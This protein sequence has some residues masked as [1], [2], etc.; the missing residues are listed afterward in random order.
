MQ[1]SETNSENEKPSLIYIHDPMCSWCWGFRPA[2][3][4]LLNSL[5][6]ANKDI[7]GDINIVRLVGGLAPDSD[8]PMPEEMKQHLSAIWRTIQQH[9]PGTEFNFDFWTE[10]APRRSTYPACR[11]VIA[12]RNQGIENDD[13]MTLAIQQAYYLGAKNPSDNDVLVEL[14]REIGLNKDVF[15]EDLVSDGVNQTLNDE[16]NFSR[17]M[18]VQGFPSLMLMTSKGANLITVD[19]NNPASMQQQIERCLAE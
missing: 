16:I 3:D 2:L 8:E 12:A 4:E 9:V 15:K 6:V 14:A 19:H 5:G 10:C 13:K 1:N 17:R 7:H 11:A 18:G